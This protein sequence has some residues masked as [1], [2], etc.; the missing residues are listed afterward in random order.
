MQ[1]LAIKLQNL[2]TEDR[3]ASA[4]EYALLVA[5]IAIIVVGAVALFGGTLS[6]MFGN[7]G[8]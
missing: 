2:V 5:G 1:K 7:L 8:K 3:G 6:T 4:V